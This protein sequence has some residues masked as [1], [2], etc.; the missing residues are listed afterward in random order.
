MRASTA[1]WITR[2]LIL[3]QLANFLLLL[4]IYANAYY[5]L[6]V[7]FEIGE[8][9]TLFTIR[10]RLPAR[11]VCEAGVPTITWERRSRWTR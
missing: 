2:G 5:R 4:A 3:A 1:R 8:G 11:L 7:S 10:R 9:A 6:Q